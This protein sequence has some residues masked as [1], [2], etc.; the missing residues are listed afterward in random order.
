MHK[1]IFVAVV[2]P[3][4]AGKDTLLNAAARLLSDRNDVVFVRR[5][6]TRPADGIT[7]DHDTLD[8]STFETANAAGKICLT[9]SA[10]GLRYGLPRSAAENVY[11]GKVVIA[12]VLRTCL[13]EALQVFGSLG[14]V[15]ID[16]RHEILKARVTARGRETMEAIGRRLSRRVGLVLPAADV[17]HIRIDNSGEICA[18]TALFLKYLGSL[19]ANPTDTSPFGGPVSLQS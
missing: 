16:V 13:S 4:G 7:E 11:A 17:N 19:N 9:W 12:N 18:A 2:G 15:E 1:G 8:D 6:I 5:I 3:S 10:H 14:I